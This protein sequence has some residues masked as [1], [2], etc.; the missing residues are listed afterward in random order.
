MNPI[1]DLTQ[2][3]FGED[4][5]VRLTLFDKDVDVHIEDGGSVAYAQKCADYLNSIPAAVIDDLCAASIRYCNMFRDDI[6]E[7]PL[8]FTCNMDV[9]RIVCP[10]VL[11]VPVSDDDSDPVVHM[12]LNCDWEEEHGMEWII[13][14][15]KVLY[16]GGFNGQNPLGNFTVKDSWNYA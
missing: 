8:T 14:G 12:E 9:L 11:I 13:R 5:I 10:S 2:G 7:P 4:G 15:D 1:R 16:V 3:E 6:G